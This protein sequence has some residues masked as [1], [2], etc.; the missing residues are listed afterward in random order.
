[1]W[2]GQDRE[3]YQDDGRRY[4]SDLSETEWAL[5]RPLVETDPT[6]TRDLR[7]DFPPRRGG[8]GSER[9]AALSMVIPSML[10][11]ASAGVR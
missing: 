10:A 9:H 11:R 7:V 6:L 4:P 8:V 3:R 5:I 1:M 2:T